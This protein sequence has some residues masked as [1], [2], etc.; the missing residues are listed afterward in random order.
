MNKISKTLLNRIYK[1]KKMTSDELS[2]FIYICKIAD[3]KGMCKGVYYR[4]VVEEIGIS[5]SQFYIVKKRLE[6]RGYIVCSKEYTQDI[7]IYIN[8]NSYVIEDDDGNEIECYANYLNLNREAFSKEFYDLKVGAK[9]ILLD[10]MYLGAIRKDK[11]KGYAKLWRAP[12]S[13]YIAYSD[14]FGIDIRTVKQYFKDIARWIGVYTHDGLNKDIVTVKEEALNA[15]MV[16]KKSKDGIRLTK[17]QDRLA[18][19]VHFVKT[20]VRRNGLEAEL[21]ELTDAAGLISQ[22]INKAKAAGLEIRKVFLEALQATVH[23]TNLCIAAAAINKYL[24]NKFRN[25]E[26]GKIAAYSI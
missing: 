24:S 15:Q 25:I 8:D 3:D 1:D 13:E 12:K 17:A 2:F 19:D 4:E 20:H 21:D 6:D 5:I 7:D 22:Y 10:I 26:Q 16:K 18:S 23:Q 9:K 11:V 14:R